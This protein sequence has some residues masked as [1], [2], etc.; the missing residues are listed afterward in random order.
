MRLVFVMKKSIKEKNHSEM[1]SFESL[2]F[3]V[4]GFDTRKS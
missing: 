2:A 4:E 1:V 3:F